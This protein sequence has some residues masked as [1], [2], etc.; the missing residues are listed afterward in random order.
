MKGK[1]EL[2]VVCVRERL[3]TLKDDVELGTEEM[4]WW[5]RAFAALTEDRVGLP[6]PTG[7]L[8]AICCSRIGCSLA[9]VG[10]ALAWYTYTQAKY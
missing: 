6:S 7:Q 8:T 1:L 3:S 9:S 4:A 5:L 10:A 2:A